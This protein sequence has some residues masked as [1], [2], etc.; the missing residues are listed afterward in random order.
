MITAMIVLFMVYPTVCAQAL[1]MFSC[2]TLYGE[3]FLHVCAV[4]PSRWHPA[5]CRCLHLNSGACVSLYQDSLDVPCSSPT[6][7]AWMLGLGVP[8]VIVVVIGIPAAS[9]L[10]LYCQRDRLHDKSVRAKFG[11]Y[12]PAAPPPLVL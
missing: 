11:A 9:F 3:S 6:H 5:T 8:A 2:K 12:A 10:V 7:I 4:K 1:S